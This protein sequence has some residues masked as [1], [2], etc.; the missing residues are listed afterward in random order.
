MESESAR[1]CVRKRRFSSELSRDIINGLKDSIGG[2]QRE[3]RKEERKS[4]ERRFL[5]EL[6]QPLSP[7][8]R[9]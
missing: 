4:P 6:C 3:K 8:R 9:K 7:D 1:V 5:N 2:L